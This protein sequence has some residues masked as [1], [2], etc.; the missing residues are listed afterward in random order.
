M[1]KASDRPGHGC[2][3]RVGAGVQ[4]CCTVCPTARAVE[5]DGGLGSVRARLALGAAPHGLQGCPSTLRNV[6]VK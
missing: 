6:K 2:A 4:Y 1:N 5:V 3:Y